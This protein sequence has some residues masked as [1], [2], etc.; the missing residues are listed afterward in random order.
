MS[1][2]I[3]LPRWT[4]STQS[5][6]I[7]IHLCEEVLP[8]PVFYATVVPLVSWL[9]LKKIIL[10]PIAKERQE[11]ERQRS[12]E[13]NYERFEIKKKLCLNY[14][15]YKPCKQQFVDNDALTQTTA[16]ALNL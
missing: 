3:L 12:M 10:D 8:S 4:C 6:V 1:P 16:P 9:L 2:S 15:T 13:A 7:P 5:I 14:V 11:R